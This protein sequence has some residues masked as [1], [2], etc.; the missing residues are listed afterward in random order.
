MRAGCKFQVAASVA[1][2]SAVGQGQRRWRRTRLPPGLPGLDRLRPALY[3]LGGSRLQPAAAAT[4]Q[5]EFASGSVRAS[6]VSD[7][8]ARGVWPDG[9]LVC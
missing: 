9:L 3:V 6:A 1:Q 4:R 2:H 8:L 7:I 5:I